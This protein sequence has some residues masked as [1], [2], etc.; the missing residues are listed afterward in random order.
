MLKKK[1]LIEFVADTLARLK[2]TVATRN[3]V[4]FFDLN[5]VVEDFFLTCSMRFMDTH[6]ST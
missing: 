1:E 3:A 5:V 4:R 2:A 6:W